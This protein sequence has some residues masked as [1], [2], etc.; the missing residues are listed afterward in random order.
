MTRDLIHLEMLAL[1]GVQ[2]ES[3]LKNENHAKNLA[4]LLTSD[5]KSEKSTLE[6]ECCAA[7]SVIF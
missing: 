7:I 6:A 1:A 2:D 5:E 3:Q 4:E